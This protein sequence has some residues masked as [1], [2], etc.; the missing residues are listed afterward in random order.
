MTA[1]QDAA[2]GPA[3]A[4]APA[5]PAGQRRPASLLAVVFFFPMVWMVLSSFKTNRRHL[6]VAVRAADLD[7]PLAVGEGLGRRP[8]RS[9]RAQQRH[10][11]RRVRVPHPGHRRGRGVRVQPLPVPRPGLRD[12]P[13]RARAAAAAAVVLHRAVE[14]VHAAGHHRHRSRRSSSRTPRWACRSPSTC[15]RSTST[16]CPRSSSR[17]RASMARA[18]PGSS[19]RSRCRCCGRVWRRSPSSRALA[20]WNEFLLALLYIQD[21]DAQDH[22]D[23]AAGVLQPLRDRLLAAVLGAVHR[24]PADDR[25]LHRLQPPHRGGHHGRQR[26]VGRRAQSRAARPRRLDTARPRR[27]DAAF[28]SSVHPRPDRP[29]IASWS[30]YRANGSALVHTGPGGS[31]PILHTPRASAALRGLGALSPGRWCTP[32]VHQSRAASASEAWGSRRPRTSRATPGPVPSGPRPGRG[33]RHAG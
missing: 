33:R 31:V 26:E 29:A 30:G 25:H 8:P 4:A 6:L 27:L 1:A 21:D 12:G 9:L 28:T 5:G 3:P 20:A 24:D 16:R 15:S 17:R 18:T 22:P 19:A 14:P 10:R 32:A 23:R 2:A 11:D 7:R 13:V